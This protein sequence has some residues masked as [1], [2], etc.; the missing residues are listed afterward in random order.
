V[1]CQV[2]EGR[3][4]SCTTII[5]IIARFASIKFLYNMSFAGTIRTTVSYLASQILCIMGNRLEYT[6][7]EVLTSFTE[8]LINEVLFTWSTGEMSDAAELLYW[9]RDPPATCHSLIFAKHLPAST[10]SGA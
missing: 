10:A 5:L 7:S 1:A 3:E 9:P 6:I 8:Y 4:G 2:D